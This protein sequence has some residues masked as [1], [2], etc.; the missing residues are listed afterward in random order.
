MTKPVQKHAARPAADIASGS[1]LVTLSAGIDDNLPEEIQIAPAGQVTTRDA[2]E[3]NFDPAALVARFEQDGIEIPID[4]GHTTLEAGEGGAIGWIKKLTARADGLFGTV[5]WLDEG[6]ATLKA[7]THR[8]IS[9]T[10][11]HDDSGRATW[12][13]SVALVSAPALSMPAIASTNLSTE[14]PDMSKLATALG[15]AEDADDQACLDAI[16]SL[17]ADAEKKPDAVGDETLAQLKTTSDEL[18]ALKADRRKEKVDGILED[19][20]KA[21]KIV[22]AQRDQYEALC[23]TDD[24]LEQVSKL[25][26]AMPAQ[27]KASGLD[28]RDVP[29]SDGEV[30]PQELAALAATYQAEQEKAGIMVS[31]ADAVAH[32]QKKK[33]A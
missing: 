26:D 1:I 6:K 25:L 24:G 8:Y 2:R 7:R 16:A 31:T 18:A 10:F 9:P 33:S 19:A 22:P 13:H 32:V 12:V 21:K 20:L 23:A 14:I 17:K 15:L 11:R 27:L 5:E 4:K 29:D 30:D 28:E 3:F